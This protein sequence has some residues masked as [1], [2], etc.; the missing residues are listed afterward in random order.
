MKRIVLNDINPSK[1]VAVKHLYKRLKSGTERLGRHAT[2]RIS[3]A[4]PDKA[5]P[6]TRSQLC[7]PSRD[8]HNASK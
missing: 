7:L 4:I 5:V 8:L 6:D 1:S 2:E 3:L